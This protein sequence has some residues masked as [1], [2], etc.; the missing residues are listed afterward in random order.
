MNK[1]PPSKEQMTDQTPDTTE[2]QLGETIQLIYWDS[3]QVSN[4]F[5]VQDS[6]STTLPHKGTAGKDKST[7][8]VI[9]TVLSIEM[10]CGCDTYT[11]DVLRHIPSLQEVLDPVI[12]EQG[13]VRCD[14]DRQVSVAY[15]CKVGESLGFH[16]CTRIHRT[17]PNF[18]GGYRNFLIS[19]GRSAIF[20]NYTT[21]YTLPNM[22]KGLSVLLYTHKYPQN[23]RPQ[24]L[25]FLLYLPKGPWNL[26]C[27]SS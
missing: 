26:F 10:A 1:H 23:S 6:L 24:R 15:T 19:S 18:T 11:K 2:V 12:C 13:V 25:W 21:C 9:A 22:H 14:M 27:P 7:K 5:H 4:Y 3:L 17:S 8:G 16:R 20:P